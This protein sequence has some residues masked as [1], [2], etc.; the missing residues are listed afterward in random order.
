MKIYELIIEF[1]G[2][3]AKKT[4]R[5]KN[6]RIPPKKYLYIFFYQKILRF[7]AHVPWPCHFTSRI[8]GVQNIKIGKYTSPG[9]GGLQYINGSGGI[10]I[11]DNVRVAPGVHII[12]QNHDLSNY[13]KHIPTRPINIGSNV[14]IGSHA[15]I[16]PGVHIGDNVVIGAGSIVTKDI[17]P[18]SIAFGNPCKV[19]DVKN[20]Y[21]G[22]MNYE[23]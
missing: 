8:I 13:D 11:G 18:N 4:Y 17:P 6:E 15:V 3:L 23:K 9:G 5:I 1:L 21:K 2:I 10:E 14:W 19:R 22:K 16:L 20:P 7:N 12:S